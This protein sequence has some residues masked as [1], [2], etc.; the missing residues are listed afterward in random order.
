MSRMSWS[1]LQH[2]VLD[3]IAPSV[4]GRVAVHQAR[5]RNTREEAGRVW[6]TLD[7]QELISFA[8]ADY[9]ARRAKLAH[10]MRSGVGPFALSAASDH[11]EYLA[12][13]A[14]AVAQ[15]RER[16]EY[17]DYSALR[18]LEDFLS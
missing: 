13:D 5:Y 15:L 7:G 11:A 4:R 6:I 10:E 9:V 17:D 3:R 8:T 12:A 14:A 16:G 1:K 18:D 2:A